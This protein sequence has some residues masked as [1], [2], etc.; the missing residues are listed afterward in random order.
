MSLVPQLHFFLISALSHF[1]TCSCCNLPFSLH[2]INHSQTWS[3]LLLDI[4]SSRTNLSTCL[5]QIPFRRTILIVAP[6]VSIIVH[7]KKN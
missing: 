7:F 6:V 3:L 1:V 5:L 4:D 2:F